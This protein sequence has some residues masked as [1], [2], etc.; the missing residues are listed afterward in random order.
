MSQASPVSQ[1]P[2]TTAGPGTEAAAHT[3]PVVFRETVAAVWQ[4]GF[5]LLPEDDG[6]ASPLLRVSK[7]SAS[8]AVSASVPNIP[9]G[10]PPASFSMSP[11]PGTPTGPPAPPA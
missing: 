8:P 6:P 10:R 1:R 9:V 5:F 4:A 2:D 7:R 11:E 3:D